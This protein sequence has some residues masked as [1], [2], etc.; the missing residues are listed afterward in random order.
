MG[1]PI[2]ITGLKQFIDEIPDGNI[3]LVEGRIDPVKSFFA[4]HLGLIADKSGKI[5]TYVSSRWIEEVKE[6]VSRQ[7]GGNIPFD[8]IEE[9]S[10]RHWRDH[11]AD[12]AVIIIDSFSYL[13]LDKTLYEFTMDLE[14]LRKA[15]KKTNTI[16]LLIS[17]QGM[18]E[19][20]ME[21][22]TQYIADGVIRFMTKEASKG[23]ARYI[24]F[25]KW[26]GDVSFDDNIYYTFDGKRMNVD[27]RS[28]VV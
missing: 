10:A 21:I 4:Q 16:V 23:I 2:D 27:L 20:K 24:R 14:H 11:V 9:R 22:T 13:T 25:P 12:D 3:I 15:V 28:R 6:E 18:L 8:I 1:I 5:V 17:E 26:I 19:E 7:N